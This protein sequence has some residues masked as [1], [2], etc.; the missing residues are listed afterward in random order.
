MILPSAF[1]VIATVCTPPFSCSGWS[2][3][4]CCCCCCYYYCCCCRGGGGAAA[5]AGGAGPHCL[6]VVVRGCLHGIAL[7]QLASHINRYKKQVLQALYVCAASAT[8]YEL[9]CTQYSTVRILDVHIPYWFV[10]LSHAPS[11]RWGATD[12]KANVCNSGGR[13]DSTALRSGI[14]ARRLCSARILHF[15]DLS[16]AWLQM[17]RFSLAQLQSWFPTAERPGWHDQNKGRIHKLSRIFIDHS[18][19]PGWNTS[20]E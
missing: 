12:L 10:M 5:A 2:C 15:N 20:K 19:I 13:E 11:V 7:L 4:C 18:I 8:N 1:V 14:L 17:L 6:L 9:P 3:W 16:Q